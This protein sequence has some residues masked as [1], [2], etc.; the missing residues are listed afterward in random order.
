MA[1]DVWQSSVKK[2]G[3]MTSGNPEKGMSFAP[4]RF[5]VDAARFVLD[6][7]KSSLDLDTLL[8]PK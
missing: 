5:T 8:Q 6:S 4:W 3:E 7:L 1:Y 2:E